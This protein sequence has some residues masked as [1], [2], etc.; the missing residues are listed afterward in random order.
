MIFVIL[1][2]KVAKYPWPPQNAEKTLYSPILGW[3]PWDSHA[4]SKDM[5]CAEEF[6]VVF[7]NCSNIC[8]PVVQGLIELLPC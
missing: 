1:L 4:E 6:V 5:Q 2:T 8:C 7:T 3:E